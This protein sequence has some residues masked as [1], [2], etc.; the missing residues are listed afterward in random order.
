M[1]LISIFVVLIYQPLFNLLIIIYDGLEFAFPQYADMG[2]AVIVFTII[3]RILWL[4]ISLSADRSEREK[5][6]IAD[7]V[8][9]IKNKYSTDPIER[10]KQIKALFRSNP[11]PVAA[12]AID[13]FFQVLI[14][15]MLYRMFST[16]LGGSDFNLLYKFIPQPDKPFNLMFLGQFDLAKPSLFLNLLQSIFILAAEIIMTISSP[17]P[18]TK[19]DLSTIIFLPI[20]SFFIF[21]MMPAGKKLFIIATIGFTIVFMLVKQIIFL[22]HSLGSKLDSFTLKKADS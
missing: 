12:S 1:F 8:A 6:E 4:P 7:K 3:F 5:R 10:R 11:G 9:E 18:I 19:R 15:I 2:I 13:L 20:I 14:A 16:G 22:Y 21:M 17:F